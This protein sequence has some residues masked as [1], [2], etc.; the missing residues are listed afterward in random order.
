MDIAGVHFILIAVDVVGDVVFVWIVGVG[1]VG[2]V[3]VV[4][5][6][7]GV[8]VGVVVVVGGVVVIVVGVVVAV[9]VVCVCACFWMNVCSEICVCVIVSI[10]DPPPASPR[11]RGA[12]MCAWVSSESSVGLW[13][14]GCECI[15][16]NVC[17]CASWLFNRGMKK[18]R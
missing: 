11:H 9:V 4:G 1:G 2:V 7:V 5:D 10:G 16:V 3:G 6:G 14:G 17:M 8:V 12:G 13:V 15:G 18:G